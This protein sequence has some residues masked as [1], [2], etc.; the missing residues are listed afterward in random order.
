MKHLKLLIPALL[1]LT[2]ACCIATV[3]VMRGTHIALI[4]LLAFL[5]SCIIAFGWL[6][7]EDIFNPLGGIWISMFLGM[8]IRA[9]YMS[10]ST[11][12]RAD[13]LM[14]HLQF[15][16]LAIGAAIAILG[17]L[18]IAAG[19]LAIGSVVISSS[20]FVVTR[21]NRTLLFWISIVLGVIALIATVDFLQ[22]TGFDPSAGIS[23]K[24]RVAV[25]GSNVQTF[26]AFGYHLWFCSTIPCV[27]FYIW[28]WEALRSRN[29][30]SRAMAFCFFS[31]AST[32]A[33]LSSNRSSICLLVLNSLYIAHSLRVLRFRQLLVAGI[34][35]VLVIS[36]GLALRVM[37]S[38]TQSAKS[39]SLKNAVGLSSIMDSL[40]GNENFADLG[41]LTRIYQGVPGLMKRKYGKSY[42]LWLFAPVPRT[43]WRE[44]PVISQGLEIS[45][46][47]YGGKRLPTGIEGGGRPPGL[48]SEA[49][50]NFGLLGV[51]IV[52][53]M[54]GMALK[55][56]QNLHSR[57]PESRVL[58]SVY[59]LIPASFEMIG[60]E[61]SRCFV[62]IIQGLLPALAILLITATVLKTRLVQIAPA[63]L[64]DFTS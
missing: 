22:R 42:V 50:M 44:K 61:F 18:A 62:D 20:G 12:E 15:N 53:G 59:V 25:G 5:P 6:T 2:I 3:T 55:M 51:P 16:D 40:I 11:S 45:E 23:A 56:I 52:C 1:I 7:Q 24:R 17:A 32:F 43:L 60:G 63:S 37:S 27:C 9:V 46:E 64:E 29:H 10:I 19:Y 35:V 8:G 4:C 48:I 39:V 38:N 28:Y 41:R 30:L 49:I 21:I 33:L 36:V 58:L 26:A 14:W 34:S 57:N 47:I 54:Y 31:L 13:D